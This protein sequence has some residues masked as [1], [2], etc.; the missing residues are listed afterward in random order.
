MSEI[1]DKTYIGSN[2]LGDFSAPE[3]LAG[4]SKVEIQVDD[5]TV[6]SAGTDTGR[7]LTLSC[8]YGTEAMARHIL[9]KLRGQQ[10]QPY[11]AGTALLDPS[12]ELGDAVEI[13]GRYGGLYKIDR[14]LGKLYVATVSAPGD[15]EIDHEYPYKSTESRKTARKFKKVD[16]NFEI[17]AGLIAARVEKIG[18]DESFSW[19]LLVDHMSWFANGD[20]VVRFDKSGA[21][22]TGRIKAL[23][24]EIGGFIIADGCLYSGNADW[25]D[26]GDYGVYLGG[27]GIA[28]GRKFKVDMS[29]HLMAYDGEFLGTVAAGHIKYG[30]S[31]NDDGNLYNY[32]SFDGEGLDTNSVWGNR[33]V[34]H[35]VSTYETDYDINGTLAA[36]DTLSSAITVD[37]S[38]RC[39]FDYVNADELHAGSLVL[40]VTFE[41]SGYT[42]TKTVM[43]REITING[44]VYNILTI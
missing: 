19:E 26:P 37:S 24:G 15:E 1:F 42:Q 10:Y 2:V 32:G 16:A 35:D 34:S 4:W 13:M 22:I 23:S 20:E 30:S 36:A 14:E 18:G 11:S 38:M 12:A 44:Y 17:Q 6:V 8:P 41:G 25:N 3:R 29:G 21:D 7:T 33:L 39:F 5:D 9:G 27:D 28:A 43:A 40:T 31:R